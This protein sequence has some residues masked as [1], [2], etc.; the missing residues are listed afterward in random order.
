MNWS[1]K[2]MALAVL[3][4]ASLGVALGD[5][6]APPQA[7][8]A[9][10]TVN[11]TVTDPTGAVVPGAKVV[12]HSAVTNYNQETVTD[13]S[14]AYHFS[15][16]PPNTY[17]VKVSASG[18]AEQA[19]PLDVRGSI[20]V[21]T[22]FT[23]VVSG[24][25]QTVEVSA[26]ASMLEN[27]PL[28]HQDVD[29]SLI[30]KLPTLDPS[31]GFSSAIT[32][33]SGAVV[34][35]ANGFFHPAGDH[36]QT[37]FVIDG[38]PVSDQQSKLFSTQIPADA[39]QGMEMITGASD[40]QYGD[41]SSL[42]VNATTKSGLG[43]TKPFGSVDVYGGSFGTYGEDATYGF[44]SEKFGSFTAV[45]SMRT[46]RFLDSPEFFPIHDIGNNENIFERLDYQLT[47][48]DSLH[49]NL[50]VA[51]NW[52]QAPNSFD[53]LSQDQRQRVLTW[54]VAPSYQHT[55]DAR[56]LLSVNIYGRRDQVDYYGSRNP[57]NDN[58]VAVS[59]GRYLTNYGTRSSLSLIRGKHNISIGTE[60]QQTRLDERFN[61]GLTSSY[62]NPVCLNAAAANAPLALPQ[63]TDP[64][65]CSTVSPT[66]I[67]NPNLLPGLVPFD[68]T[69]G[70]RFFSFYGRHNINQEAV[71]ITD[72]INLG[73]WTVTAGLR[74]DQYNGIT[75]ANGPQPRLGLSYEVKPTGTVVRAS[76]ARTFESPYNENL[77]LSSQTGA[78]GLAENVFG[79]AAQSP[80]LPGFRNQFNGG[81]EQRIGKYLLF[82]GDYF[83]KYTHNAYDFDVLFNTPITFPIAWHNSKIDGFSGRLSTTDIH[84]FQ[85][86][87]TLGHSRA[88]FFPPENG[89][90]I[91]QSGLYNQV[92]RIDHD[93][94]FQQTTSLRYQ[95]GKDGPWASFIWRYDSGE[96]NGAV[97]D[98]ADAL[99]LTAAQQADIGFYCGNVFAT[100]TQ[101]ISSC[102]SGGGATRVVIPKPGTYN[103]DTNPPRIAPR[104]TFD[105]ALGT[106]NLLRNEGDNHVT[107]RFTVTN[108]TNKEA[109][110]NF[111]STFS[112]THFIEPRAYQ[113]A[114]GYLF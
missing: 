9:A 4:T 67:A 105:A 93:Q 91:A 20:P 74:D 78:G 36:A 83:W 37:T 15:N 90:L 28:A 73:A 17:D 6:G 16:V 72:Q 8:C 22:N 57:F 109:L 82:S 94:A 41:K 97:T 13:D 56:T 87:M 52:F 27:V 47:G 114:I 44:G 104:N 50:F 61:M 65:L 1:M 29:A 81:F 99:A 5:D 3:L 31:A 100:R 60:I 69:R 26:S 84:G 62:F 58:P 38:Q 11:G 89:G 107:L 71:Y 103:P 85:A 112:G 95:H 80:I 106:D 76:Y 111:L 66:Y 96:V 102:P 23:L 55:F 10:C 12:I 33:S 51:R 108:L 49:L 7:A 53:Q 68:L 77:L 48:A 42:V 98:I 110:Y 113:V 19:K 54:N 21:Q 70:G 32:Y 34:A 30:A 2:G 64:A 40:A 43:A 39:I 79:A 63:I 35:D 46:G 101:P 88:R 75:S 14:G 59:Q 86:F 45:N 18:F 92:F 25:E 24:A